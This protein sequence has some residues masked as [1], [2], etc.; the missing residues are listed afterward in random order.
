MEGTMALVDCHQQ[1]LTLP[2]STKSVDVTAISIFIDLIHSIHAKSLRIKTVC[3]SLSALSA[4]NCIIA[5]KKTLPQV[6][7]ISIINEFHRDASLT[8]TSSA[9][10]LCL[11]KH[12]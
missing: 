8:K 12:L 4:V 3:Y 11:G 2:D 7:I 6:I 5:L 1:S 10:T 9:R